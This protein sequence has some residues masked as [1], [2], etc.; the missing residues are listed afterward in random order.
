MRKLL[1]I[2]FGLIAFSAY[3]QVTISEEDFNKLP[4]EYR[5]MLIQDTTN[6][7]MEKLEETSKAASI[8]KEIGTAVNETLTAV[9][10]N[11]IKIAE[12]DVGKTAVGVAVW[13]LLWK[14]IVG[15]VVGLILLGFSIYFAIQAKKK[16]SAN[17]DDGG[18][19]VSIVAA[20]VLFGA[21]MCCI[22]G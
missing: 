4:A 10:D 18:G 12:S 15:I 13:K 16:L 1:F 19:I 17:L 9:S 2:L 11:V 8:G 14:D 5:R 3:S 21:S 20:T 6:V 22:F 7:V